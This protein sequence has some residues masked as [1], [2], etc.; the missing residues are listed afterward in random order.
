MKQKYVILQLSILLISG[1]TLALST[2]ETGNSDG[3]RDIDFHGSDCIWI[4]SIRDYKPLDDRSL[5]IW[6][7]S[8]PY[9]VSLVSRSLEMRSAFRMSVDSRDDRLC[10]YGGDGLNFGGLSRSPSRVRAISRISKDQAEELLVRYG[11]KDAG[12]PQT[13]APKEIK[14]ADVAELD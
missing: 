12:E 2:T 8:R 1:N 13:P 9:Y 3:D 10:P 6:S 14:G 4:R 7:G 5:L 11:K